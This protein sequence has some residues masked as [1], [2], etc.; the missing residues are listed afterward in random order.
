MSLQAELDFHSWT[1]CPQFT[2]GMSA[3]GNHEHGRS[4]HGPSNVES[5]DDDDFVNRI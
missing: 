3:K 1:G 5:S 2:D 4:R